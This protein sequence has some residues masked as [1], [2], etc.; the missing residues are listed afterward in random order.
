MVIG[1]SADGWLKI[2]LS[3]GNIG[4]DI[5]G[6]VEGMNANINGPCTDLPIIEP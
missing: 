3:V 2:D 6:W 4:Q 5:E 1:K